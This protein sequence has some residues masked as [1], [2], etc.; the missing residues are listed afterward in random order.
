MAVLDT[1][2]AFRKNALPIRRRVSISRDDK[3]FVVAFQPENLI[4]FRHNEANALRRVCHSLR[5][6]IISDTGADPAI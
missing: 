5:W 6:E 2:E 1:I 4:V 3:D